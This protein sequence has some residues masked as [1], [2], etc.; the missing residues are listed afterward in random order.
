[1]MNLWFFRRKDVLFFYFC[2]FSLF[3]IIGSF[4]FSIPLLYA[5]IANVLVGVIFIIQSMIQTKKGH[6]LSIILIPVILFLLMV[7]VL[8]IVVFIENGI[9]F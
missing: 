6:I 1:M 8:L 5:S 2:L 4:I 9:I 7:A 3:L